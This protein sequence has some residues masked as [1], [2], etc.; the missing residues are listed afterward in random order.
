[1]DQIIVNGGTPLVGEVEISGSKNAS[2]PILVASILADGSS[3]IENVPHLRDVR[4]ICE[5]LKTLGVKVAFK[6]DSRVEIDPSWLSGYEAPYDLVKT[7]RASIYVLGALLAKRGQ[8]KVSLPGGCAIGSRPLDLHLKG[9]EKLGVR[10]S[11]EHGYIYGQAKK[12]VGKE[13]YL[14]VPSLGATVNIM[15]AAV[16][17]EGETQIK[18]AAR[19]PEIVDLAE[20]LKKMGARISGEG[21]DQI[22]IT[23][24]KSLKGTS[25]QVIPDRIEA[26]SYLVAAIITRGKIKIKN[27]RPEHLTAIIDKME[28][29]GASLDL[30][31]DYITL[32]G[33]D[34]LSPTEV[35]TRPYPGFPTDMQAQVVALLTVTPGTSVVTETVWEN[36]FMHVEELERM[37]ARIYQKGAS[38]IIEGVSSL[39]GAQVMATDLRASVALIIAG[40][41]AGGETTISRVYH[42]DR[43]YE[44]LVD[45]LKKLG[46]KIERR[47]SK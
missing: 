34:K 25:Y 41:V 6:G 44:N 22:D 3:E 42:L 45:K 11:L 14:D 39:S 35:I 43:G 20:F 8:A 21:T 30:G 2:L 33:R 24:V 38:A 17:A 9:L 16:L 46:A 29:M 28:E 1:M 27:C 12:L 47:Q 32:V 15:L 10:F 5:V 13:I 36:R 23:G 18:N 31:P 37:G 7:M 26:G 40:L 4:T 19:D